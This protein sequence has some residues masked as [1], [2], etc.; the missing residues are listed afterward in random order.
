M[1]A[2]RLPPATQRYCRE[3]LDRHDFS[4]ARV[5]LVASGECQCWLVQWTRSVEVE[6]LCRRNGS[7]HVQSAFPVCAFLAVGDGCR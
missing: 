1:A 7:S 5:H 3:L 6:Q 4:A 2:L